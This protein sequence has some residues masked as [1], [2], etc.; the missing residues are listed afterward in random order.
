MI[1][2][3]HKKVNMKDFKNYN[4]KTIGRYIVYLSIAIIYDV[5]VLPL[6]I[7]RLVLDWWKENISDYIFQGLALWVKD[8]AETNK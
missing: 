8:S 3:M 1:E 6:R 4:R 5:V 7:V 2:V